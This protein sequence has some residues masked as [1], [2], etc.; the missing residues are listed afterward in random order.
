[1]GCFLASSDYI[2]PT[3]YMSHG[4]ADLLILPSAEIL[5]VCY[6]TV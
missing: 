4:A 2:A 3:C 5:G 6:H 1:V